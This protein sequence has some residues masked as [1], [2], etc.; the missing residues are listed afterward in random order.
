MMEAFN[1][2]CSDID[3][4][5]DSED[6]DEVRQAARPAA[7]E[8]E[9]QPAGPPDA[10]VAGPPAEGEWAE[11]KSGC[12]ATVRHGPMKHCVGTMDTQGGSPGVW[13]TINQVPHSVHGY[14]L[15]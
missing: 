2:N 10:E 13:V 14:Q 3:D 5:L 11:W 15:A 8:Q 7:Q 6:D 1:A 9:V 12:M 4:E